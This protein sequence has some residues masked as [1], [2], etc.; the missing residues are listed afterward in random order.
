MSHSPDTGAALSA[1][2][3]DLP[4]VKNKKPPVTIGMVLDANKD[5]KHY[6][7]LERI[8]AQN[9]LRDVKIVDTSWQHRD[10]SGEKLYETM[11]A[12]TFQFEDGTTYVAYRGTGAKNWKY[13]ADSAYGTEPSQMQEW[14][15]AYCNRTLDKHY[16]SGNALYL[17]GHSQGGNNA[18]YSMLTT[19]Y[20]DDVTGCVSVDGPGFSRE[21]LE[22]IRSER[23]QGFMDAQVGKLTGIYGENDFVHGVGEVQLVPEDQSILVATPSASLEKFDQYHDIFSHYTD[24]T[25]NHEVDEP[26][27]LARTMERVNE[28][29]LQ[30]LS[31]EDRH[32]CAKALMAAVEK[33][34]GDKHW[35]NL[36]ENLSELG[37]LLDEGSPMLLRMLLEEP[38]ETYALVEQFASDELDRLKEDPLRAVTLAA[39]SAMAVGIAAPKVDRGIKTAAVG[40]KLCDLCIELADKAE[41]LSNKSLSSLKNAIRD[42]RLAVVR[43]Q[44]Y[45]HSRI[46]GVRYAR[47]HPSFRADTALLRE[48]AQKLGSIHARVMSLDRDL[49][50]LYWQVGLDDLHRIL[51]ANILAGYSPRLS[52]CRNYLNEAAEALEKAD[53]K[54]RRYMGG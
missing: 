14:A 20:A 2:L 16:Q 35:S 49:N 50:D 6:D 21:I 8:V 10:S 36:T 29:M 40:L 7:Q 24:G 47:S 3:Y 30:N 37:T 4:S 46:P 54:A 18:M 27:P 48:Y 44:E 31:K 22:Q 1:L 34:I 15:R 45:I 28:S 53:A 43:V 41:A 26:G 51:Q 12:A 25:L 23:G 13:N 11:K 52:L 33:G 38:E 32:R 5:L 19:K 17:A 9:H 42:I 39:I